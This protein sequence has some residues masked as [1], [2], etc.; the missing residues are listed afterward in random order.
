MCVYKQL[1]SQH[2]NE[3]V[4][5]ETFLLPALQ[6]SLLQELVEMLL[7]SRASQYAINESCFRALLCVT[8]ILQP[9]TW[10]S[11]FLGNLSESVCSWVVHHWWALSHDRSQGEDPLSLSS[12]QAGRSLNCCV[13]NGE[14]I[15]V[16][17]WQRRG[18]E[19][20]F[21][22]PWLSLVEPFT[23]LLPISPAGFLIS[24]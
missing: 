10:H 2:G 18:F 7:T 5:N 17:L 12:L 6:L 15:W 23:F 4:S 19:G 20:S 1:C 16:F 8:C 14:F 22:S 24:F 13:L 3:P 11:G 21:P 9:I